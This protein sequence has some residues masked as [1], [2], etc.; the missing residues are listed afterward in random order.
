M[1]KY[2]TLNLIR[3]SDV[4][5]QLIAASPTFNLY[6]NSFS[7]T[8]PTGSSSICKI[9]FEIIDDKIILTSPTGEDQKQ[10]RTEV[11]VQ[12]ESGDIDPSPF[13]EEKSGSH[14]GKKVE[15]ESG[16]IDPSRP[17]TKSINLHSHV[18]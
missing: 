13:E 6:S 3:K 10:T 12:D 15:R 9:N 5:A 11:P 18:R 14:K 2:N 17:E 4:C 7:L 1:Y 16:D 8:L